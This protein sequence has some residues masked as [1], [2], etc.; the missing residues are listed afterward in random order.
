MPEYA[1]YL[2]SGPQHRKTQVHVLDLLGCIAQ[3]PITDAALVATPTAIQ[4]WLRFLKQHG[5][6]VDP[7]APF[8]TR[9]ADHVM[10]GAWLGNGDPVSGFG[11]DFD[12]L[13]V[14]ELDGYLRHLAWLGADCIN[15]IRA[16]PLEQQA[17]A[18]EGSKRSV[19]LFWNT[20]SKRKPT[21]CIIP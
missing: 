6:P 17:V 20:S 9:V 21:T 2:E 10:Q 12:P 19:R 7:A 8:T 3:G 14:A 16:V 18:P 15:L 11:P 4:R 1:L 13:S 5:E